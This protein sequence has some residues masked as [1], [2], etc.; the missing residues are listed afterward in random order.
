MHAPEKN[1]CAINVCYVNKNNEPTTKTLAI[2]DTDC[3]HDS[4]FISSL[5]LKVLEDFKIERDKVLCIVSDNATNM[6]SSV[7][8]INDFGLETDDEDESDESGTDES[9]GSRVFGIDDENALDDHDLALLA[10]RLPMP[11]VSHMR[12]GAHTLQL[13]VRDGL[14][15]RNVATL[16][17][18]IRQM[19]TVARTPKISAILLKRANKMAILD[20]PTRW[21]STYQ[22]VDRLLELKPVLQDI[23]IEPSFTEA[24]WAQVESLKGVLGPAYSATLQLQSE[25]L[26]PGQFLKEWMATEHQLRGRGSIL[27]DEI[28]QSMERREQTLY[29]NQIFLAGV[30][31]DPKYRLLLPDNEKTNAKAALCNLAIRINGIGEDKDLIELGYMSETNSSY[32]SMEEA[33]F[34]KILDKTEKAMEEK[35]PRRGNALT[36]TERF[37]E[38]FKSM[39]VKIEEFNRRSNVDIFGAIDQYPD[40][41][42]SACRLA[43][44]LPPTQVSVE[45]LFSSLKILKSDLRSSLKEDILEAMLFLRA[46]CY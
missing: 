40:A 16:L 15:E 20:Q 21:G 7:R 18:K 23:A 10:R 41:L 46:N 13:A 9:V 29:K 26:T 31:I 35:I 36:P 5:I 37:Q 12:C 19:V 25:H 33:D 6:L 45:R 42:K 11:I 27:S 14:K 38:E 24:Q 4:D 43:A 2:R 32:E 22:M 8:K 30:Y 39:I 28:M 3:R 44:A 17:G 34:E 1:Y